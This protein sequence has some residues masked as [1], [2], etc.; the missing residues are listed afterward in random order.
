MAYASSQPII[1]ETFKHAIKIIDRYLAESIDAEYGTSF[2]TVGT[3]MSI[4]TSRM[5]M[6]CARIDHE[7][8]ESSIVQAE[9]DV[10]NRLISAVEIQGVSLK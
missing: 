3:S 6:G 4:F 7:Q 8:G 9:G 10:A 5:G 2:L 1:G